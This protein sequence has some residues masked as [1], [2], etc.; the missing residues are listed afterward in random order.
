MPRSQSV[1][2]FVSIRFRVGVRNAGWFAGLLLC[3]AAGLCGGA[4]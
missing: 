4:L 2:A 1:E 3:L